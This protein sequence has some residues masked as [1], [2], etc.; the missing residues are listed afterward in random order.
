M[1]SL[2]A[3]RCAQSLPRHS[4][5]AISRCQFPA[6]STRDGSEETCS[7]LGWAQTI[8]DSQGPASSC[9]CSCSCSCSWWCS[10]VCPR[11]ACVV[12]CSWCVEANLQNKQLKSYRRRPPVLGFMPRVFLTG[13]APHTA[14]WLQQS[15]PCSGPRPAPC[16]SRYPCASGRH[17]TPRKGEGL[18]AFLLLAHC[19]REARAATVLACIDEVAAKHSTNYPQAHHSVA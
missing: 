13:I 2:S 1:Q 19:S 15:L 12:A 14:A 11:P 3:I 5:F 10:S 16:C 17:D 9:S 7:A 4:F 6:R 8:H 18:C